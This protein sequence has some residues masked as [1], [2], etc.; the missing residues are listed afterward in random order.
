MIEGVD[1]TEIAS[2][3]Y[4][5]P[6]FYCKTFL[7]HLF[8]KEIPWIHRGL[9]AILTRQSAFL[10]EY[11]ECDKIRKNFVVR[12]DDETVFEIFNEDMSMNLGKYTVIM[13]PRGLSKTTIAGIAMPLRDILFQDISFGAYVSNAAPHAKMQLNN[14]KRELTDNAAIRWVFGDVRPSISDD[15][16][17]SEEMFETLTG[18]AFTARG[19]GG[20]IRGL[21]HK[22]QRPSK[23]IC[24]DLEDMESVA[25][26]LQREKT[27]QW[28]YGDLIPALP[29][30]DPSATI[31]V[32]GTMLHPDCLLE[33]LAVDPSWTAVRMGA[34]DLDGDPLWEDNLSVEKLEAKK[35]SFTAA[36]ELH[37]FYMEYYNKSTSVET[38]AFSSPTS[39]MKSRRKGRSSARR[40]TSIRLSRRSSARTGP[41]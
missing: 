28:A 10:L 38:Q 18:C 25:T 3:A 8:S 22:G 37:V 31:T 20:Q 35:L 7:P 27:R 5:D 9:M 41:S 4:S 15:E 40:S 24:D 39:S 33:T 29:E 2:L 17:W 26:D 6:V 13:L 34:L 23:I 21:N 12:R 16:K 11:G 19:R 1:K 36:G 30:L 14:I 32:L